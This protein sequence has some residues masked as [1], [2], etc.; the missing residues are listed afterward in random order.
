VFFRRKSAETGFRGP[1]LEKIYRLILMLSE[2]NRAD[3]NEYLALR[4]GTAINLCYHRL[5]R[6]SI[7]ID[8]VLVR[9][10]DSDKML[11][12]REYLQRQLPQIAK[13]QN[14]RV[15]PYL[16]D[17][18]LDIF[19][20]KYENAFHAQDSIKVEINYVAGRVPI[21]PLEMRKPHDLFEL[22]PEP[23]QTLSIH[24]V[25][26]SKVEALIKRHAARDLFDV[27]QLAN[28]SLVQVSKLRSRTLFSCCVE[29][30][31]DFR[32]ALR[33]NPADPITQDQINNELRPY[34]R[35]KAEFDL[36]EAKQTVGGFC[37]KLL[38]LEP[39]HIDFLDNLFDKGVYS[40]ELL[41]P[42]K[43][44]LR[45]HPG[46]KWRLQQLSKKTP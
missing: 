39:P 6:L 20:L 37:Q 9:D 1:E 45:D 2:I 41:F 18:S 46:M 16:R 19:Q 3:L 22:E 30:P 21:D 42:S 33:T 26:A 31:Y 28:T 38:N 25:Y 17:Y 13:A 12:D 4:G 11:A 14:Y 43:I 8:I 5:P 36:A 27:Y 15:D 40:P 32:S 10:G 7:D 29:L 35:K 34:L 44:H 24:E 23:V